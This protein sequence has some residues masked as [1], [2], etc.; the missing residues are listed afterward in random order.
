[1]SSTISPS[2][3]SK[4]SLKALFASAGFGTKFDERGDLVVITD[5]LTSWVFSDRETEMLKIMAPIAIPNSQLDADDA[6]GLL[7]AA[8]LFNDAFAVAAASVSPGERTTLIWFSTDL[9]YA[10]GL[11][12][13]NLMARFG[14][15]EGSIFFPHPLRRYFPKAR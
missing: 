9:N 5:Q 10:G 11:I 8:N 7:I 12:P 13:A 1:M 14:A 2:K 15:F 4:R 6:M 3:V